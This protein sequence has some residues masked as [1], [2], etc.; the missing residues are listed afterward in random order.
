M[1]WSVSLGMHA[2]RDGACRV[3][4][5]E[6]EGFAMGRFVYALV[7]LLLCGTVDAA[8]PVLDMHVHLRDGEASLLEYRREAETAGL[9]LG[10]VAA[11]W[12]GGPNQAREGK[13]EDIRERNDGVVAL[14]KRHPDVVAVG[15]V[16]PY[17]GKAALDELERIAGLG[18]KVLKIHPHT[19]QFDAADPR[20][21]VLVQRAGELGV[22][23]LVDN[24][25]IVVGD[26]QK[27]FNLAVQ[28]PK[29]RFVFA[30]MGGLD[31]RFWNILVLSRTAD[32]FGLDNVY[33]DLSATV[34]VAADTPIE[35]EFIWTLR[36]VGIDHVLLGSDYPQVSLARTVEAL[37][38]LDLSSDEKEK[39]R[40]GNARALLGL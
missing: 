40:V 11:M 21:L 20:V 1:R 18:V 2:R 12:F 9:Q 29:T 16:H 17:D 19:Q 8:G 24:A 33:F 5:F 23:V 4:I 26:N 10:G 15:T 3:F 34:L 36:N 39:I 14:A 38:K 30:H 28:A 7:L 31:F 22:V 25:N 37:E 35:E 13:P 32:G 6:R 27:L